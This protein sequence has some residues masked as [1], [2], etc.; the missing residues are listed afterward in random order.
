VVPDHGKLMTLVAG[1]SKRQSLL[2]TGD[3][4][5]VFMTRSLDVMLKA[6]EQNL[7]AHIAKSES[8]VT[9]NKRLHSRY[10]TVEANY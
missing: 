7:I 8:E 4:D 10:C 3:N 2:I 9:N 6:R 1:S 5:E